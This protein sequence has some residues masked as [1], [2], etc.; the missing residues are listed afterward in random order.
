[1]GTPHSSE[2]K[3]G[4]KCH[5]LRF[6][7]LQAIQVRVLLTTGA[8]CTQTHKPSRRI[9][10]DCPLVTWS[11]LVRSLPPTS[12]QEHSQ[13]RASPTFEAELPLRLP[14]L[15]VALFLVNGKG[16]PAWLVRAHFCMVSHRSPD[17]QGFSMDGNGCGWVV[18]VSSAPSP[19][20]PVSCP[21]RSLERLSTSAHFRMVKGWR[22]GNP[23]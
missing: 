2:G 9:S 22:A 21:G 15:V 19:V 20:N 3:S 1:M 23:S 5:F 18:G 16:F 13:L 7:K 14:V 8:L 11:E 12:F 6:R 10:S 17:W 4:E